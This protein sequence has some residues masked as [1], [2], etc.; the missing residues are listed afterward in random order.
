MD[1]WKKNILPYL[2]A[3]GEF[4]NSK[5]DPRKN[6]YTNMCQ[7]YRSTAKVFLPATKIVEQS[8]EF[9]DVTAMDTAFRIP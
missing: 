1:V 9:D 7:K 6:K 3:K 2:N 5:S 4:D 8:L